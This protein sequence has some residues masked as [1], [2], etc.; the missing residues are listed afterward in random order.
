MALVLADRVL[1]T[2]TTTG[3]GT[4]TLAGAS[5]GYQ[6]FA[7]IG[8]GNTTY[9]TI[10]S[11][12]AWEV[13]IGTYSTTGP[14]LARTTVLSSSAGGTTKISLTGTSIV[15]A[16][17]PAEKSVNYDAADKVGIGTTAP[18]VNLEVSSATGSATPTPT[19]VRISTTTVASDFSTTLPWG[20][21]SFYSADIS[22]AGP[23]IQG[24]IDAIADAAAG[25]RMSMVFSTS[26]VTTGTLTERMRLSA[27]GNVTIITNQTT[28]TWTAGGASG[29]G[30]ITLGQ[31]TVSQTTNIQAG[32]TASGS[33]KAINIG[34]GGLTGSTTTITL[35]STFG[36][37]V[38]L[39]SPIRLAA[40]TVATLPTAGTAGR[41]AYV[42]DALAPTFLA[43]LVGGGAVRCP[44]FDNGT[45]WVAG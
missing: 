11:G 7:V 42:T 4:I 43:A 16:T 25:G 30:T 14:T 45:T 8:N 19:E 2:T 38:V 20:R 32:A 6:S 34:T 23:K 10:T 22:D 27:N 35:G 15:F 37:T 21:L 40:F 24:A 3:T 33:T 13:G 28:G 31:S 5:G 44:A 12:T 1:E 17:Y 39:N 29:T 9:Y 36:T 41:R 26:I 18:A